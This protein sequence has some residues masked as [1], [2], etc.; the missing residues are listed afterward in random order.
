MS[1]LLALVAVAL[2]LGGQAAAGHWMPSALRYVDLLMLPVVWYGLARSQ[3][4]AMLVGCL[5]GALEDAWFRAGV[6]GLRG[7]NKTLLGWLVGGLGAR[8]DLNVTWGRAGAGAALPVADRLLEFGLLR[9]LDLSPGPIE[10]V[11]LAG[12]AAAGGALALVVFAV[13]DRFGR[14]A[15]RKAIPGRTRR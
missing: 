10:P 3:R 2:A 1:L 7:F 11:E 8:L 5:A 15:A 12:R 4:S 13:V 6:F 14:R 9:L